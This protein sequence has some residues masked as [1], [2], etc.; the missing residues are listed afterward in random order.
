MKLYLSQ[1]VYDAA[2]ERMRWL[3][4]EFANVTVNFSG[5]KD[6]TV[7]LNLALQVAEEKGRLPLPVMFIDQEAEW[8]S[9]IDYVREVM[10]DPRVE[11]HW[12]QVPF[13]LF[14]AASTTE[15]WLTCWEPGVEW[16]RPKEP[17]S[18]H[19]NT[20]GT[21]RFTGLFEGYLVSRFGDAPAV[22][23]AGVR[24]EESPARMRGLTSY[25]TYKG[26]TWGKVEDKKRGHYTMY[27]LYD[28]SYTDI[29]TAIHRNGWSYCRLYD[30]MYQHGVPV[31][32]MRVSS[33]THETSIKNLVYLQ[34]IEG[35][36]W[37]R[38]TNRIAGINTVGH[39]REDFFLPRELPPMFRDWWEY[40]DHLLEHL[41]TDPAARETMRRQFAQFD[42]NYVDEIKP[43]LVKVQIGCILSNDYHGTKL[44]TF[45]A[46]H[47]SYSKGKGK[48]G[49]WAPTAEEAA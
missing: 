3:F 27:P 40:R 43:K 25:A 37:N 14:N 18:V 34:E 45:V 42:A 31:Q 35:A 41:V 7:C 38:I 49:G 19:E 26:E 1:T 36:T 13:R 39:M 46:N 48:L 21:D 17:N 28:W 11:P 16:V 29:W 5:G 22:N 2:L 33:V 24:T 20:F 9:V 15:P 4:D 10:N 8:G 6:S 30:F 12:L 44:S 32:Q 47:G 23:I